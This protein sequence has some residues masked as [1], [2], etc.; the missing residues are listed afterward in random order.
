[1]TDS[2]KL[3][4]EAQQ[5][6]V[7]KIQDAVDKVSDRPFNDLFNGHGERFLVK[8][9]NPKFQKASENLGWALSDFDFPNR[10]LHGKNINTALKEKMIELMDAYNRIDVSGIKDK[11]IQNF[12]RYKIHA[13]KDNP[14]DRII[15]FLTSYHPHFENDN[16][17]D[18]YELYTHD[19]SMIMTLKANAYTRENYKLNEPLDAQTIKKLIDDIIHI[20]VE[21]V[22]GGFNDSLNTLG[23]GVNHSIR[24]IL[25]N[26]KKEKVQP[27]NH[28][29]ALKQT[30]DQNNMFYYLLFSRHPID[31]LRMADHKGIWSCHRLGGG[32]YSSEDGT[33]VKCAIAD[34]QNDGGIVYLIKGS[35]GKRVRNNLNDKDVFHDSDRNTGSITPIGRIRL[36]RFVDIET[37]KDFAVPTTLNSEQKYG[38]ITP[39]I[40]ENILDYVRQHQP[41]FK[42][43]PEYNYAQNNIVLVGGDYSDESLEYLL[44]NFFGK[45]EYKEI[46][47]KTNHVVSWQDEV[48]NILN[49]YQSRLRPRF[50]VHAQP[51]NRDAHPYIF[52]RINTTFEVPFQRAWNNTNKFSENLDT[53]ID[54]I[55][56]QKRLLFYM[57]YEPTLNNVMNRK[58]QTCSWEKGVLNVELSFTM[59]DPNDMYTIISNLLNVKRNIK[60]IQT[61]IFKEID[62]LMMAMQ[63]E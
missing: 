57:F 25:D 36:R 15:E 32:K 12:I 6:F 19:K 38:Y 23:N 2:F 49:S 55:N 50:K 46:R 24:V 51:V 14:L 48:N 53:V 56:S 52:V 8:V 41:I 20:R 17:A 18:T 42:N 43:P 34:A 47:H 29:R 62:G 11:L 3:F 9:F 30:I 59:D 60:K 31:V 28:L 35:D 44:N 63:E 7:D 22:R 33:Y 40:Y 45:N 13:Y 5:S 27:I 61:K 4:L 16:T 54:Q 10:Q 21:F 58:N 37:G 1:M 39:D 26:I